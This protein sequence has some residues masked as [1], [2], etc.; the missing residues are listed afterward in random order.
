MM[1]WLS[2][3]ERGPVTPEP[4]NI[5]SLR[6]DRQLKRLLLML[7]ERIGQAQWFVDREIQMSYEAAYLVHRE[8][9]HLRAYLHV[10]GQAP[11]RAGLH[12][13][14]PRLDGAPPTYDAYE[15]LSDQQ[16][17]DMLAA[18]FGI[19]CVEPEKTRLRS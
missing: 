2:L 12:L 17:V 1:G 3:S 5:W 13:E 15:N 16:L 18:H 10:H 11:G 7:T 8:D 9:R 6:K 19:S 14:Y 4:I